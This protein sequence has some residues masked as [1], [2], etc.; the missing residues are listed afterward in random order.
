LPD[1]VYRTELTL[2]RLAELGYVDPP[3]AGVWTLTVRAGTYRLDCRAIADPVI[4]CGT[5]DPSLGHTVEMGTV[6]GTF[7]TVWFVHDMEALSNLTGCV[8][9]TVGRYGCGPEGGYHMRWAAVPGGLMFSDFVGLGDEF[10]PGL[11][12]WLGQPWTRIT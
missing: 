4:D 8:R 11:G 10:G 6:R 3:T 12:N 5:H 1:G 2:G 9:H 7:H